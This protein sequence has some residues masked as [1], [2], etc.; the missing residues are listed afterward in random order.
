MP[1]IPHDF[2]AWRVEAVA[3]CDG[4]LDH[5]QAGTDVTA[6]LG[7]DVDQPAAH[8]VGQ[9]LELVALQSPDILRSPNELK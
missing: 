5:A 1:D 7:D 6:G 4:Q 3:E 8:L 2:V 9:E